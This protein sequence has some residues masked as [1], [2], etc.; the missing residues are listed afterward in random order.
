MIVK[1]HKI[2]DW[3]RKRADQV[4]DQVGLGNVTNAEAKVYLTALNDMAAALNINFD[5][6]RWFDRLP[7]DA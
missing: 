6:S 7:P 2:I 5:P 1:K 4:L 3:M